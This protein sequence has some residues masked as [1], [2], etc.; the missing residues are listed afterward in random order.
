MGIITIIRTFR[1][2]D[3][4]VIVE[5]ATADCPAMSLELTGEDKD[6][7]ETLEAEGYTDGYLATVS[8]TWGATYFA[9]MTTGSTG[10]GVHFI[11][12]TDEDGTVT[13]AANPYG[14]WFV[15]DDWTA[16]DATGYSSASYFIPNLEEAIQ[17]DSTGAV[18]LAD[19]ADLQYGAADVVDIASADQAEDDTVTY[20]FL[21]PISSS[22]SAESPTVPAEGDRL[23]K[24]TTIAYYNS[25]GD[26]TIVSAATACAD[27]SDK[28]SLGAA[29]LVAGSVAFAAALAF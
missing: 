23:D 20:A 12:R 26:N 10:Y 6:T 7:T 21:M 4:N 25:I 16:S 29:T 13:D 9:E 19:D 2:S 3:A 1:M 28:L 24:G 14:A 27:E 8:L 5:T 18:T 17:Y 22:D 11:A 15:E